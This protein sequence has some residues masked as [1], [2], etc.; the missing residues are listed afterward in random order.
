MFD[1]VINEDVLKSLTPEQLRQL[2]E[3]LAKV[4]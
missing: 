4:K 3:I 2:E 1:N